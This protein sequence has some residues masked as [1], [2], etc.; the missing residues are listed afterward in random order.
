MI[1][2]FAP[3]FRGRGP[4]SGKLSTDKLTQGDLQ[5]SLLWKRTVGV[6][7]AY[8]QEGGTPIHIY[9]HIPFHAKTIECSRKIW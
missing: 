4:H 5:N 9:A 7:S 6:D 1:K 3:N 8:T 2:F